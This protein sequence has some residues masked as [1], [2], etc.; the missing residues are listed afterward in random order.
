M[1]SLFIKSQAYAPNTLVA[2]GIS[3]LGTVIT[4]VIGNCI[5]LFYLKERIKIRPIL[6][7]WLEI[8]VMVVVAVL[9]IDVVWQVVTR[10]I[11]RDP[12]RWTDELATMLLIWVSLLGASVGFIRK[13]HL[14]VDYF[15]GKLKGKL[16]LSIEFLVYLLIIAFAG[17]I[18]IYGG[19]MIVAKTL[20]AGQPS[21]AL[22]VEM[23]YIYLALPISGIFIAIFAL[24]AAIQTLLSLSKPLTKEAEGN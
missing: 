19:Y 23:G 16:K 22:Q 10:F 17:I 3:L 2:F 20:E 21:P 18:L 5:S 8:T 6:I 13:V 24:E 12:S 15:V 14:G 11:M 4:F 1:V 9:V 7:R